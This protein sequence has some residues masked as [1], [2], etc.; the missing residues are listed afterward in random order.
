VKKTAYGRPEFRPLL[1][2]LIAA[3]T[4]GSTGCSRQRGAPGGPEGVLPAVASDA[5][6]RQRLEY[7]VQSGIA[8]SGLGG[9]PEFFANHAKKAELMADFKKLEAAQTPDQVKAIAKTMLGRL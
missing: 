8:G 9:L 6:L 5:E 2:L 1:I 4:C 7:M 3:A